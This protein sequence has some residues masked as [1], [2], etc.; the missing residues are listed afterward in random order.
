MYLFRCC[1]WSGEW[2]VTGS[3]YQETSRVL[4]GVLL[5]GGG[6]TLTANHRGVL[7][8]FILDLSSI[9][10]SNIFMTISSRI[11]MLAFICIN[12]KWIFTSC[13][14]GPRR[15]LPLQSL[16]ACIVQEPQLR[17][18]HDISHLHCGTQWQRQE[19]RLNWEIP[20]LQAFTWNSLWS[21]AI[22]LITEDLKPSEGEIR[23]NPKLR[24][25]VYN[26]HFVDRSAYTN[27]ICIARCILFNQVADGG[28]PCNLFKE[29][30]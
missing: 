3:A 23:R 26:Q 28:G 20:Y 21:T 24:L 19:V 8:V 9:M 11:Y 18:G 5:P 22:K 27:S 10:H 15:K 29:T 12:S 14:I 16:A 4:G 13:I 7:W 1:R 30:L 2:R 25:G 6:S 17:S